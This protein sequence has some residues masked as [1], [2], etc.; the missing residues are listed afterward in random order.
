VSQQPI[1]FSGSAA[2][3]VMAGNHTIAAPVTLGE[4][5]EMS[6]ASG[7]SLT[8]TRDLIAPSAV[9]IKAGA[10]TVQLP[11]AK[12]DQ[13]LIAG[14]T[15]RI[16]P[17]GT[18]SGTSRTRLIS[19]PTGGSG[20]LDLS[21]NDL[22]VATGG[23]DVG[24]LSGSTYTGVTGLIERGRNGGSWT[25][26]GIITS[27]P[28]ATGV[29]HRTS[30]GVAT[31]A[32]A[33]HIGTFETAVWNG[34]TVTGGDTLVMYTY[35]GDATLDGKVNID[36]YM[37]IDQGASAGLSGW[38]NGDFNYDGM[39]NI[40]DYMLID[41]TVVIQGPSLGSAAGVLDENEEN[42]TAVPEPMMPA[43]IM[44]LALT[45]VRRRRRS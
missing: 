32:Q 25:G 24:T 33:C 8:L 30:L 4:N 19:I 5:L 34:Q 10:G 16:A 39:V 27:Q 37:Q 7:A 35:T 12:V 26:S 6:V 31:A 3:N 38:F 41:G 29:S 23:T 22:I 17:N 2:I 14:G 15:M 28:D 44:I 40:D 18:S 42:I 21:D 43:G 11:R 36:D 45:G 9:L 13:L 20:R 1:Q